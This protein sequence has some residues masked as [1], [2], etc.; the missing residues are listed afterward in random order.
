MTQ[1]IFIYARDDYFG[2]GKDNMLPWHCPED[3]KRFKK[4]TEGH[5]I[6]MGRKT[7]DSLPKKPLPKRE[8]IVLTNSLALIKGAHVL[9][10]KEDL[11][12]YYNNEKIFIIGGASL[13]QLFEEDVDTVYETIIPGNYECDVKYHAPTHKLRLVTNEDF[14]GHTLKIWNK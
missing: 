4:L 2:I 9:R 14:E 7:W 6:V 12:K 10:K 1:I 8:N 3:L 5:S 13:F 11:K